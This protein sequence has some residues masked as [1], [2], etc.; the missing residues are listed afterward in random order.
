MCSMEG[1]LW[2]LVGCPK[3]QLSPCRAGGHKE[4][5]VPKVLF[6]NMDNGL[7]TAQAEEL[8]C[9]ISCLGKHNLLLETPALS[10]PG[11]LVWEFVLLQGRAGLGPLKHLLKKQENNP[12]CP[13]ASEE[14]KWNRN[15]EGISRE[16][17]NTRLLSLLAEN[18]HLPGQFPAVVALQSR[19]CKM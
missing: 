1:T 8:G 6:L 5:S 17:I 3:A 2:A 19:C 18:S 11:A 12:K 9:R 16:L 15:F 4:V 13:K 14:Q 7:P 10:V